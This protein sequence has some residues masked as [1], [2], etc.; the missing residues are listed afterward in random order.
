MT[1]VQAAAH[2]GA[3]CAPDASSGNESSRDFHRAIGLTPNRRAI[4]HRKELT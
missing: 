2:G 1:A 4:F 3:G